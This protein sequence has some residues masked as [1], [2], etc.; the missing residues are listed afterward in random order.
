MYNRYIRNDSETYEDLPRFECGSAGNKA[1]SKESDRGSLPGFL[2]RIFSRLH[3]D[4]KDSGDLILLLLFFLLYS[5]GE[6]D[7]LLIALALLF[8]L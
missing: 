3:P 2:R 5:E 6:D 8:L 7:E 4:T 1:D